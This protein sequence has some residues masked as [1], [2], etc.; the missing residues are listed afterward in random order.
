[1]RMF[2]QNRAIVQKMPCEGIGEDEEAGCEEAGR[3][4]AHK[5]RS[6]QSRDHRA[7]M[8]NFPLSWEVMW[9]IVTAVVYVIFVREGW[10]IK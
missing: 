9:L 8:L 3:R 7:C 6:V 4:T 2:S 1:M 5:G 10:V